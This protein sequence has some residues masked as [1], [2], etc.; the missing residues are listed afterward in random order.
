MRELE[1][2]FIGRGEVRGF[3]FKQI[4]RTPSGYLYEVTCNGDIHFEVFKR[5]ENRRFDI[6][7]YPGSKAFGLWA[8]TYPTLELARQKL[9]EISHS[10]IENQ[11]Y[12]TTF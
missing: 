1:T 4:D 12:V 2:T 8:W 9:A 7:S 6:V 3:Q 5:I 11:P 10:N